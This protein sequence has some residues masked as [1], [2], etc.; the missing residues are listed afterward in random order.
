MSPISSRARRAALVGMALLA[1][2]L[3]GGS[4]R[5]QWT[6]QVDGTRARFRGLCVVD[7]RVVWASGTGGTVLRTTDG[8]RAWQPRPIP[9][10]QDLDFRDIQAVDERTAYVLS[11]GEGEKSRV[12]KTTD[13]V[14]TW[15]LSYLNQDPKGFLDAIAFRDADH[16]LAF[17][18]P[19]DGRFVVRTTEDGGRTWNSVPPEG[20]PPALPG[21]GAFA[22]SGTCLVVV[23]DGRGWFGTGGARVARV[24][25]SADRGRTWTAHETPVRAGSP[26][27]GLFSLAF[28]D[29]GRGIAVGGDYKEPGRAEL[30]AAL[31]ADEG[32]TW[33][34]PA[35][36]Q[37]GGYRSAVAIVPGTRGRNLV[38]VGPTGTDAS[39]DGGESWQPL[40]TT[41]FNAVGFAAPGAGWA[42]GE[43]LIA[44]FEGPWPGEGTRPG[45]TA[46][47][48][49]R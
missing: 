48:P 3:S 6:T 29:D 43:G 14:T 35:G 34:R 20:M 47:R 31:T 32:R 39:T 21:E 5:G 4:S 1:V 25:R 37:P 49:R 27:A 2:S 26:S 46:P 23:G 33:R 42:A 24:F 28:G 10:T 11:I 44:R 30:V 12:Y 36:R 8:G 40:G 41:G 15:S 45:A 22:A 19:V 18:D 13:G 38:A 17:G 16:G 9:G 7:S